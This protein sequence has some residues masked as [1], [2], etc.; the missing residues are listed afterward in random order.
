[1]SQSNATAKRV[2]L[3]KG[4][5]ILDVL[6]KQTGSDS[7]YVESLFYSLNPTICT[8]HIPKDGEYWIPTITSAEATDREAVLLVWD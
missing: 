8:Q 6:F 4:E 2:S 3:A 5:L 7:D 1:M